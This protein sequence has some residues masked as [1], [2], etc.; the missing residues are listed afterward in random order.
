MD[1][2]RILSAQ[3]NP[4][5]GVCDIAGN[6]KKIADIWQQA[7]AQQVDLVVTPEQSLTGYPLEDLA[8]QPD[9]LE[10]CQTA[11]QELVKFS[12]TRQAGILVGLPEREDGKIYNSMYLIEQGEI[13]AKVRKHD[14]PNE[15]VFDEKRIYTSNQDIKAVDFRGHKLGVLI[16]E[17]IW[18]PEVAG[19]LLSQGAEVL[20]AP[21]ASPWH[22]G[23][24]T[25]RITDVL[26]PRIAETQLPILY[27]NQ[28]GGMDELIFDGHS[29]ALNG[30]GTPAFI[31]KG[32]QEDKTILDL[33]FQNGKAAFAPAEITPF[34]SDLQMTWQALTLGTRDYIRK[35]G[36]QKAHLGNSGGIDSA[37][38]AALAVDAI[39]PENVD[40]YRLPSKYTQDD[41]NDDAMETANLLGANC[42]TIDIWPVYEAAM[43]AVKGHFKANRDDATSAN[44]QARVRGLLL[45][46]LSNRND[47]LLLSTGNKSE[48][49]VGWATL[50]GD[51]NGAFNPLKGVDKLLVYDL[52][53]WRNTYT[54]DNVLGPK[55]QVISQNSIDKKAKAELG[56]GNNFD[57]DTLAPYPVLTDI[58]RRFIEQNQSVAQIKTETGFSDYQVE[59]TIKRTDINE[60]KRR[61]ACPGLKITSR[62]F[63]KG[64]RV[65][66][67]RPN[68]IKM[69]KDIQQLRLAV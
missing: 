53:A 67:T 46:A 64:Y 60:F 59:D 69:I 49:T 51:M 56:P 68:T 24:Q 33:T 1:N 17:D 35:N 16:C 20:I 44:I 11:V 66:I 15:D 32:F 63:G 40:L 47:S 30:D 54:P 8:T 4:S 28:V 5:R 61:Q 2:L 43:N 55:G 9:V 39:G 42:E 36:F 25:K 21:N 19:E 65:P 58:N 29:M 27:V 13:K 34:Y 48:M 12:Q 52:A 10:S 3:L 50:Y 23:K 37:V 38:V 45:M 31:A 57:E 6:A 22:T 18:H 26:Q 14:L 62:D 7:D 41:S